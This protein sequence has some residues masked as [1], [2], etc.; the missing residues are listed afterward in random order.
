MWHSHT[1]H[2]F[3]AFWLQFFFRRFTLNISNVFGPKLLIL[4]L[5]ASRTFSICATVLAVAVPEQFITRCL[6]SINLARYFFS[7]LLMAAIHSRFLSLSL[8]H[9][10]PI[11]DSDLWAHIAANFQA[12]LIHFWNLFASLFLIFDV[13]QTTVAAFVSQVANR[14]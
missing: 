10:L 14:K 7:S 5:W 6:V 4:S 9:S 2:E 3:N 11:S 8:T 12:I 1:Q 13:F